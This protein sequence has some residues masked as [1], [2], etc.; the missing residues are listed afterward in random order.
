VNPQ[1]HIEGTFNVTY[2]HRVMFE[3]Q[4]L[5]EGTALADVLA[6]RSGGTAETLVVLDQGLVEQTPTLPALV[7]SWFTRHS[8][9]ATL[10]AA[11]L[12]M[13]GSED[14]KQG[15]SPVVDPVIEAI[16]NAGLC[17]HS[18]VLAIGGGAMLDAVGLASSLAHRGIGL[19]RMPTTTLAQGD[20]GIGVKN[21]VNSPH[22]SGGKNLVGTFAVPLGVIND[23]TFLLTLDDTHWRGGLA[24]SIKVAL[25][26]DSALLD[27]VE[28]H[29]QALTNRDL[30]CMERV[31]ME[32]AKLHL[33]HITDGGDP[34][35]MELAR[36]LDFGHW[37]AHELETQS[38]WAISHGEAVAAGMLIDLRVG[39]AMSL[40]A[41]GTADRIETLLRQLGFLQ[42]PHTA[43]QSNNLLVGLEHFRQHLGGKLTLCMI[44]EPGVSIDVHE[45]DMKVA[46]AAID[47]VLGGLP[48]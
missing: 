24:E 26:K 36:P 20:A 14:A 45:V 28:T 41:V 5:L 1:D 25:V 30:D 6:P 23:S 9:I 44:Q 4:A 34:F 3:R 42:R 10:A 7:E 15:L 40:T 8:T 19:V 21:G 29:A 17:R 16:A 47:T 18:R 48:H 2:R 11:P 12:V 22:R 38:N 37:A 39:E 32:T 31:L 33:R 46:E 43:A 35:E 13:P 27:T